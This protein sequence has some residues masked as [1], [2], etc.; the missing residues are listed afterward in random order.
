MLTVVADTFNRADRRPMPADRAGQ[1]GGP[2]RRATSMKSSSRI[3][4]P[5]SVVPANGFRSPQR[6][7]GSKPNRP[8]RSGSPGARSPAPPARAP[9]RSMPRPAHGRCPR[10]AAR[11]S[12]RSARG[13]SRGRIPRRPGCTAHDPRSDRSSAT[14][15]TA[16]EPSRSRTARMMSTSASEPN[17]RR[18]TSND[19]RR[20]AARSGRMVHGLTRCPWSRSL[21]RRGANPATPRPRSATLR[22]TPRPPA[23]RCGRLA[24]SSPFGAI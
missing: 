21:P 8:Y 24:R 10:P 14:A 15:T 22:A 17:A 6:D 23:A 18:S 20:S 9:S 2:G 13:R 11:G 3:V 16:N 12:R 1:T 7:A 19:V 4:N 5:C